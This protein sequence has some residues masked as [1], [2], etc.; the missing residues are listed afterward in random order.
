[1]KDSYDAIVIG[2]GLGG[3]TAANRLGRSS[4]RVLLAEQHSQLGG[5]ATYFRRKSH[6]FDVA[7]HGFPIGMKKSLR[8]YW[9]DDFAERI[10]QVKRIRF[11]NPQFQIE[12]T[13]DMQDFTRLL[14]ER[15]SVPAEQIGGFFDAIGRMNFYDD[16]T[17][18]TRQLFDRFFPGRPDVWRLLMEPIT[19][20][21]GSSLF[22]PAISYGI[23]FGNFMSKGVYTFLGGTDLMLDMMSQ[24][25]RAN[26]VDCET[27]CRVERVLL[28]RGRVAGAVINGREIGARAVISNGNL[29]NTIH[30]LVGDSQLPEAFRTGCAKVR[31]SNS[32]CQVYLGIK[33]GEKLED[34]G[35]LLFTSTHPEFD[36]DA[37]CSRQVTSRT[38][39]VYYPTI[40][41]DSERY[42]IVASMNARYEDWANLP[43]P[44]YRAAKQQMIEH[45]LAALE[46]YVPR[47]RTLIDY[48]EAA[49]PRTF[50]RYTLHRNGASFGTK[51]EGL[52]YSMDLP[53]AVPGLF[54]TGSVGIIM[55]GW[56]GSANYGVIVANEAEKYLSA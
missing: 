54:H 22:E 24:A 34:I 26:G 15:F 25:L 17:E 7:L 5:L 55:S 35:D 33:P 19:Y 43:Q 23:V 45:T 9:G 48:A 1:M 50:E 49:T 6:I 52:Q 38:Y 39:S 51:F 12:T 46:K 47:I 31:L 13:F 16:Q 42:T 32:S 44:E 4:Y 21:N 14:R 20:A 27:E 2:S 30:D 3:L 28:D 29:L 53:K 56:L 18:V 40:R 41:P 36:S 11:D 10:V 37:I 8:K